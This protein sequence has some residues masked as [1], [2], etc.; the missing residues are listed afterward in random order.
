MKL[1]SEC[2][3]YYTNEQTFGTGAKADDGTT[4]LVASDVAF[5]C[6]AIARYYYKLRS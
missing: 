6:G 4:N 1:S 2:G 5:P 3:D